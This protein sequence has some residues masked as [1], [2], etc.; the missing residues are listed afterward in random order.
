MRNTRKTLTILTLAA[1][2]LAGACASEDAAT[3]PDFRADENTEQW[4]ILGPKTVSDFDSC[5]DF[6]SATCKQLTEAECALTKD[7]LH[8]SP[9][10]DGL[11]IEDSYWFDLTSPVW[12]VVDVHG[13]VGTPEAEDPQTACEGIEDYEG[14]LQLA[15]AADMLTEHGPEIMQQSPN[16]GVGRILNNTITP[17]INVGES[18]DLML[19]LTGQMDWNVP[20]LLGD[21]NCCVTEDD[22]IIWF[23]PNGSV[24][25][26]NGTMAIFQ[27]QPAVVLG[28]CTTPVTT[29]IEE[30]K[31]KVKF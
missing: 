5:D 19:G 13:N 12:K 17:E 14:C 8:C 26:S 10:E 20:L 24:M 11:L 21:Y 15:A 30:D 4:D 2:I 31:G 3:T 25:L 1:G 16:G 7:R 18:N 28:E 6:W 22:I 27:A 23:R 29:V 9:D